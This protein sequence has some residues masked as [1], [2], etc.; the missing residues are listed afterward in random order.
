LELI[1]EAIA[2]AGHEGKIKIGLDVAASEF[3]DAKTKNYNMSVKN[4]KNDRI[5]TPD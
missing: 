4:G 1:T 3:I 5:Y 2:N